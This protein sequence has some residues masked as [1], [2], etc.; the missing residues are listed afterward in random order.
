MA[1]S[2]HHTII[3]IENPVLPTAIRMAIQ[4]S[5]TKSTINILLSKSVYFVLISQ[6]SSKR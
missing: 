4:N 2:V 1:A 5:T 3:D 6:N